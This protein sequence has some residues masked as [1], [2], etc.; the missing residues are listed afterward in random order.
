MKLKLIK[1]V[2]TL[3]LCIFC[4]IF[5]QAQKSS[6][7]K[8][9]TFV[10]PDSATLQLYVGE[11]EYGNLDGEADIKVYLKGSDTLMIAI[12][13]QPGL[14]LVPTKNKHE[15]AFKDYA[16]YILGFIISENNKVT[17]IFSYQP[18]GVYVIDRKQ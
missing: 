1:H 4:A 9:T 3:M 7:T 11:Y 14:V 12:A 16:G 18:D 6:A 13:G 10:K 17:G 2:S 15:F 5:T 8:D